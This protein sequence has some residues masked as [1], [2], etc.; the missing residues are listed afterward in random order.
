MGIDPGLLPHRLDTHGMPWFNGHQVGTTSAAPRAH[1]YSSSTSIRKGYSQG[2]IGRRD[3]LTG[4]GDRLADSQRS[5]P[6]FRRSCSVSSRSGMTSK[7]KVR[8]P[9]FPFQALSCKGSRWPWKT[10]GRR[11][12]SRSPRRDQC[13]S[14]WDLGGIGTHAGAICPTWF[15]V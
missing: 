8:I 1:G 9:K 14:C 13:M 2:V 7:S 6:R 10:K 5:F 3:Q 15:K 12:R 4:I 11:K